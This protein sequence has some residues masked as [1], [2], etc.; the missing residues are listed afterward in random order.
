MDRTHRALQ[1]GSQNETKEGQPPPQK[2]NPVKKPGKR[3]FLSFFLRC[4]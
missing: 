3:A 1:W 4:T 2:K